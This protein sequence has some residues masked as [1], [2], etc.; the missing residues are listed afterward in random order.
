[1]Q[2][3]QAALIMPVGRRDQ[4]PDGDAAPVGEDMALGATLAPI[5]GVGARFF[6]RPAGLCAARCR[7]TAI[8]TR[9]PGRRRSIRAGAATSLPTPPHPPSAGSG[10]AR[11]SPS[12]TRL[13]P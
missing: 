10:D 9:G 5:G 6:P 4:E 13:A 12:P 2:E 7:P 8:A 1:E 11:S 3:T